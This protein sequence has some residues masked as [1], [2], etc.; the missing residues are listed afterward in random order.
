[1]S[2]DVP[3]MPHGLDEI[4]GDR[5]IENILLQT[6]AVP[7][8]RGVSRRFQRIYD[9]IA[10]Y[11][12]RQCKLKY[13]T[14]L[15]QHE[16]CERQISRTDPGDVR[17]CH[18]HLCGHES[19]W[20][21]CNYNTMTFWE[22]D[23]L[24]RKFDAYFKGQLGC[25]DYSNGP[26]YVLMEIR[27]YILYGTIFN[28]PQMNTLVNRYVRS[29]KNVDDYIDSQNVSQWERQLLEDVLNSKMIVYFKEICKQYQIKL[30]TQGVTQYRGLNFRTLLEQ[31]IE[32]YI[33][34]Y[35]SVEDLFISS[36][37]LRLPHRNLNGEPLSKRKLIGAP[38]SIDRSSLPRLSL[39]SDIPNL[40]QYSS[41]STSIPNF[42]PTELYS[43]TGM[44]IP[45]CIKMCGIFTKNNRKFMSHLNHCFD[46][47]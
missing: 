27:D 5:D 31:K 7:L 38:L 18:R 47:V 35:I 20:N 8:R 1:M 44:Q 33:E 46:D 13:P 12:D 34:L 10:S 16:L 11:E 3:V 23:I 40:M 37:N 39:C 22:T 26:P 36:N 17:K 32:F 2:R 4:L 29:N 9:N 30:E 41:K 14:I 15:E 43:F 25:P 21:A 42:P 45:I 24:A 28:S 19:N 6:N